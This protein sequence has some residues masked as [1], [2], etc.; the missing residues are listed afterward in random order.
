MKLAHM[1][2][3]L[4]RDWLLEFSRNRPCGVVFG[5]IGCAIEGHVV[6]RTLLKA[7][8]GHMLR[9]NVRIERLSRATPVSSFFKDAAYEQMH[10]AELA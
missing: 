3:I 1:S 4:G 10:A 9:E 5:P 7:P 2:L 8:P 6:A